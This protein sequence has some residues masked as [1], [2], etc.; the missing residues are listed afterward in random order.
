[1]D[2]S[3]SEFSCELDGAVSEI[4]DS[5]ENR[6]TPLSNSSPEVDKDIEDIPILKEECSEELPK[7]GNLDDDKV[8]VCE[9]VV[10]KV[11]Q[12]QKELK[13]FNDTEA[14]G[15]EIAYRCPKCRGCIE[16]KKGDIFE[17]I[18][19]KEEQKQHEIFTL[20]KENKTIWAALP[21]RIDPD[22]VLK[23]NKNLAVVF[24]N[25][26]CT[27]YSGEIKQSIVA[28]LMKLN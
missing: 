21:L 23:E 19:L 2:E 3:L 16:C 13:Q 17:D 26:L 12:V 25:K 5:L 8:C 14:S 18:S 4:E 15:L 6:S 9:D 10:N 7:V 27:K 1:M 20:D 28:A 22:E 11:S 24:L